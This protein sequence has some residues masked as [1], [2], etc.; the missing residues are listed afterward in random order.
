MEE[1][2]W[3]LYLSLIIKRWKLCVASR[4]IRFVDKFL[5]NYSII[6]TSR[7]TLLLIWKFSLKMSGS[8]HKLTRLETLSMIIRAILCNKVASSLNS[9][10]FI[11]SFLVDTNSC[12]LFL[13][14]CSYYVL[15]GVI[16]FVEIGGHGRK[17][18]E[19]SFKGKEKSGMH[20]YLRPQ[21][22]SFY[23]I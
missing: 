6:R 12:S 11:L 8:I 9:C 7:V 15:V 13:I 18:N 14:L 2:W 4:Q 20:S 5:Y 1:L 22:L 10:I 16:N 19:L 21:M 17:T 23:W 3:V